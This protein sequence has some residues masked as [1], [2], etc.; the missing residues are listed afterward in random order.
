[1][2]GHQVRRDVTTYRRRHRTPA[3]PLHAVTSAA[4]AVQLINATESNISFPWPRYKAGTEMS[5]NKTDLR[6]TLGSVRPFMPD[7]SHSKSDSAAWIGGRLLLSGVTH[8]LSLEARILSCV[9]LRAFRRDVLSPCSGQNCI[10]KIFTNVP[11]PS[12]RHLPLFGGNMPHRSG[13]SLP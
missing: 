10:L 9:R 13:K 8:C 6:D 4:E 3:Q 11:K 1:V 2:P 12:S 7:P 5:G